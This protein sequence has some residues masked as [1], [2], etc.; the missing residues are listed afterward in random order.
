M[1]GAH[2]QND[3]DVEQILRLALR[4]STGNT[5]LALRERL[6]A[7]ASELGITVEQLEAAEKQY[8]TTRDRDREFEVYKK[9]ERAGFF[10]HLIPFVLVNAFLMAM[11]IGAI[12][13]ARAAGARADLLV[14][15]PVGGF[16]FT[17]VRSFDRVVEVGYREAQQ[18]IA[19]GWS[20][21]G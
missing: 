3:D 19:D 12:G 11:S 20:P 17:D 18:A 2:L 14:R 15:P 8:R 9:Q 7:S 6:L 10:G 13:S 5:G 21:Q 1:E 16:S 4:Q